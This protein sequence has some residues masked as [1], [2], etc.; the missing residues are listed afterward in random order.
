MDDKNLKLQT[1][2][3]H[4]TNSDGAQTPEELIKSAYQNGIGVVAITDHDTLPT[5]AQFKSLRRFKDFPTKYIF[6]IELTS[7]YP[8]EIENLD[9]RMFHIVGLFVDPFNRALIDHTLNNKERRR[10]KI[11]LRV[12]EFNRLGFTI[13]P[14]DVFSQVT[15]EGI[16]SSLNLVLALM[17]HPENQN[18]LESYFQKLAKMAVP[19]S[20]AKKIYDEILADEGE[21]KQKYFGLFMKDGSPFKI[22]LPK[23]KLADLDT[24]VKLIRGAGGLAVLAHWSFDKDNFSKSILENVVREKRLDGLETVYDLF[25]LNKPSWKKRLRDDRS[26]LRI[27]AKRCG[28]FISGG[29]DAHKSEDLAL[30]AQT[31]SYSKETIG[32]VEKIIA[33]GRA[34]L[35]NSSLKR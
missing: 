11:N 18:Q 4:T 19:G 27:L 16:P 22:D 32:M 2:H 15:K 6:G 25:L 35:A 29:V 31:S 3:A 12:K 8:K 21:E 28:R 20:E 1:L 5:I 23:E 30:F 9:T 34:N 14:Q 13:T 7:G 33:T 17:K 10:K 26:I 24:T